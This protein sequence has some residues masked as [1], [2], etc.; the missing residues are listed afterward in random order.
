MEIFST[1][2]KTVENHGD[3][4]AKLEICGYF[5]AYL[6]IYDDFHSSLDI[7]EDIYANLTTF[8]VKITLLFKSYHPNLKAIQA[9]QCK[10][11]FCW[12][13]N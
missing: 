11:G 4:H 7:F 10:V 13:H 2:A 3:F 8:E 1:F 5:Q 9:K 12:V 6:E